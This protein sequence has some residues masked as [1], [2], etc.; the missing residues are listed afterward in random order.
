MNY[1][2]QCGGKVVLQI[3]ERDTQQRHVCQSCA[4]VHYRNPNIVAG[5]IPEWRDGRVLLCKRSI[6]PRAECW[7]LPGGFLELGE[8]LL[9][10]ALR[11]TWEEA[12]ARVSSLSLYTVLSLPHANQVYMMFRSRLCELSFS[13][14]PESSEVALFAEQAIPWDELAFSTIHHTLRYYFSDRRAGCHTLHVAAI[15]KGPDGHV[16]DENT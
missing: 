9:E 2:S 11:E 6:E 10:G 1:C 5:C 4:T 12:R 7:T 13:P 14:G 3:P 8:T 15:R 16:L